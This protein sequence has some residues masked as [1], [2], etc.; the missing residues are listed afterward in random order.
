MRKEKIFKIVVILA[1]VLSFGVVNTFAQASLSLEDFKVA[2][3]ETKVVTIDMNNSVEIRALQVQVM[4]PSGLE[5][6]ARPTIVP[7]RQGLAVDEFG[8]K[9][10]AVKSLNYTLKSDGSCVI[11]VN[12]SDAIPFSGTEGAVINLPLKVDGDAAVGK[13]TIYLK[14]IELVYAD[15][16]TYVRPQDEVCEVEVYDMRTCIE[17]LMKDVSRDVEVYGLDGK[18]IVRETP[19]SGLKSLLSRGIYLI[20]GYKVM[21]E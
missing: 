1:I 9:I 5:L 12:A 6:A 15:G 8:E 3:G 19:V 2:K 16:Y 11:V 7:T 14:N 4:L 13:K 17:Q 21:I 18:I 20:D 10:N